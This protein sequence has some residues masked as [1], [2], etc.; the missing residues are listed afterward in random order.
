MKYERDIIVLKS[1]IY[2]FDSLE[3]RK[4][5]RMYGGHFG[6][7]SCALRRVACSNPSKWSKKG[8]LIPIYIK[9][10][11]LFYYSLLVFQ[12]SLFTFLDIIGHLITSKGEN[13]Y[14]LLLWKRTINFHLNDCKMDKN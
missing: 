11:Y 13:I 14:S 10:T 6:K 4:K 12:Y 7:F 9:F 8:A 5:K 2:T 3:N 1:R